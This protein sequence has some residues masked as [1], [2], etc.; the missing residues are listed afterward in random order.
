M[1]IPSI[2]SRPS[3]AR[4]AGTTFSWRWPTPKN[5]GGSSPPFQLNPRALSITF[6]VL[7]RDR[8]VTNTGLVW[9]EL[10]EAFKHRLGVQAPHL[11][12]DPCASVIMDRAFQKPTIWVEL[13]ISEDEGLP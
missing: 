4:Q 5:H 13:R 6:H 3:S 12:H 1:V 10:G 7:G 2:A 9:C 8:F 11:R